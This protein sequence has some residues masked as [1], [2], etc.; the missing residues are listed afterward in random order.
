MPYRTLADFLD[1]LGRAGELAAVDAEVDPCLEV[2]E[3]TRR[4]ARRNGP[5]LLFR[6]VRGHDIPLLTNLFG[7]E[8]RILRALGAESIEE[9][10]ARIDRALNSGGSDGWLD[11]LRFGGKS[12]AAASFAR[13]RE[14]SRPRASR[15]SGWAATLI[16]RSCRCRVWQRRLLGRPSTRP[17]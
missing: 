15:L 2:A 9:A 1:D 3:I 4:T 8:S 10:T 11:R 16:W 14:S 6:N 7:T 5:A 17:S 12:G 13:R